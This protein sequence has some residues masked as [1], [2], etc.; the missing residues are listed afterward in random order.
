MNHRVL[1]LLLSFSKK[2]G[3]S[4]DVKQNIFWGCP[5]LKQ[6]P[7]CVEEGESYFPMVYRF[8]AVCS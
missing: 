2:L 6:Y 7:F 3:R 8:L 1:F 5:K 4:G